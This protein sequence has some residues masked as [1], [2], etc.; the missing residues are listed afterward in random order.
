MVSLFIL[1]IDLSLSFVVLRALADPLDV[2]VNSILWTIFYPTWDVRTVFKTPQGRHNLKMTATCIVWVFRIVQQRRWY[3]WHLR[4]L[5]APVS[6][7]FGFGEVMELDEGSA[8][9]QV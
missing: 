8:E 7:E 1:I 5:L 9:G 6:V 3:L 4:R 2:A